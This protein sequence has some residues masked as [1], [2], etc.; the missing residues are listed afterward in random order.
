VLEER[1][2]TVHVS[3]DPPA[4]RLDDDAQATAYFATLPPL[5]ASIHLVG[6][7]AMKALVETSYADFEAQWRINTVSCFL[8]CREA[9]RNMLASGA[10]GRIVNVASRAAL[11]PPS[12]MAAYVAGKAGVVGLTQ[13]IAAEL[14]ADK[15]LVNA[16]APSII[17]S[18]AN[19]AAM[20]KADHASWP[21][22][23]EIAQAIVFLASP[24]NTLTSGTVVP[25]YG[26]G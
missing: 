17:D 18:P 9:A 11:A 20:P 25:V 24:E 26:R 12:N 6:G 7:F 8:C 16:V 14:L 22:P 21:T 23:V 4:L 5:W 3:P 13:S 10:G 2:A 1:G 15:I 19:R